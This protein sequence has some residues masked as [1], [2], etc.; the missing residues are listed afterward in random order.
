[1]K[2]LFIRP[3]L[4]G[5]YIPASWFKEVEVQ[6][7]RNCAYW[8]NYYELHLYTIWYCQY[9]A[10]IRQ[11]FQITFLHMHP[12]RLQQVFNRPRP[13][14]GTLFQF[15][16]HF[17]LRKRANCSDSHTVWNTSRAQMSQ[18]PGDMVPMTCHRSMK[19]QR[20]D[21]NVTWGIIWHSAASGTSVVT[22]LSGSRFIPITSVY[23]SAAEPRLPDLGLVIKNKPGKPSRIL[24]L[25]SRTRVSHFPPLASRLIQRVLTVYGVHEVADGHFMWNIKT[26]HHHWPRALIHLY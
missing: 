2:L 11:H 16:L 25:N 10:C 26:H 6:N 17:T 13:F 18:A 1:M 7:Q 21:D 23:I 3:K 12:N 14:S 8:R 24:H 4:C 22:G 15:I 5:F 20:M 19:K 9:G